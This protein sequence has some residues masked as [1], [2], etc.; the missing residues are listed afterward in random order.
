MIVDAS[1]AQTQPVLSHINVGTGV[2][3][4]IKELAQTIADVTGFKGDLNF[5]LTRPDGAPRKLLDVS[6]LRSMGWVSKIN[7]REGLAG[8]YEWF[9]AHQG[10]IR[11]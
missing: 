8:T 3:C 4:S 2:D 7:L 6:R 9:L 11:G 10:N 5:D 1:A